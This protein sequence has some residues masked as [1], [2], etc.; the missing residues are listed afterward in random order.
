MTDKRSDDHGWARVKSVLWTTDW[1]EC[2][3][4]MEAFKAA[5]PS[6][7]PVGGNDVSNAPEASPDAS[8]PHMTSSIGNSLVQLLTR[9]AV[10]I[11]FR[12]ASAGGGIGRICGGAVDDR[13][14]GGGKSVSTE[15]VGNGVAL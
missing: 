11:A 7:L 14:R 6:L 13:L 12:L 10:L 2:D 9:R 1:R 3:D 15:S 4:Q 5:S 8:V